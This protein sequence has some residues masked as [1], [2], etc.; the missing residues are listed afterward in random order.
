MTK[1]TLISPEV[2]VYSL[3]AQNVIATSAEQPAESAPTAKL[4]A[5]KEVGFDYGAGKKVW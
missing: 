4:K 3:P 1:K 5:L 2:R